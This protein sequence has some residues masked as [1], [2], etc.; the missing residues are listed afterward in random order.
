MRRLPLGLHVGRALPT[1]HLKD[2]IHEEA[3][4]EIRAL[5]LEA[6]AQLGLG[7]LVAPDG[8]P[9]GVIVSEALLRGGVQADA[10]ALV[11][12]AV[13]AHP[14]LMVPVEDQ[15]HRL[16]Q[17]VEIGHELLDVVGGVLDQVEVVVQGVE[18]L[19][20]TKVVAKELRGGA[21]LIVAALSADGTTEI[22]N[23]RYIDRGYETIE[24]YLSA[25]GANIKRK[26]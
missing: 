5:A 24:K 18:G 22:D 11:D 21:A 3:G 7:C 19:E 4:G 6:L 10:H 23:V 2:L 17:G 8:V 15:H 16:V 12:D 1:D 14:G 9:G 26:E 20:G 13:V 25:C